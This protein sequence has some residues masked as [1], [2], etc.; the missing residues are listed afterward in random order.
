VFG[1]L[2]LREREEA[3]GAV[4]LEA[5]VEERLAARAAARAERDFAR[6]DAIRD[7]MAARGVSVEDGPS[8]TRWKLLSEAD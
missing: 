8:G 5:W 6:A 1:V 7:E 4:G 2:A 3:E